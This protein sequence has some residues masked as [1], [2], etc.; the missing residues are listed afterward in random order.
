LSVVQKIPRTKQNYLPHAR[1]Y[2]KQEA[3]TIDDKQEYWKSGGL[4]ELFFGASY[5]G[6]ANLCIRPFMPGRHTGLPLQFYT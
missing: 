3:E 4:Q 2:V 5:A 6:G 1:D